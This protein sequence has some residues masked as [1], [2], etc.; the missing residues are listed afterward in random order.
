[1][2]LTLNVNSRGSGKPVHSFPGAH[3][4]ILLNI[5]VPVSGG[6]SVVGG[7]RVTLGNVC[8]DVKATEFSS[9]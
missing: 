4:T 7:S 6:G 8:W 3:S 2:I 9:P 5:S 1:M